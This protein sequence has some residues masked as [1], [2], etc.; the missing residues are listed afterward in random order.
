MSPTVAKK[1]YKQTEFIFAT[2]PFVLGRGRT[3]NPLK[4]LPDFG[5]RIKKNWFVGEGTI[6]PEKV[7]LPMDLLA[8]K[9]PQVD[10]SQSWQSVATVK[11]NP[12]IA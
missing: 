12:G 4:T 2:T 3:P 1:N 9:T 5:T 11:I 6:S 7:P 10:F 8:W